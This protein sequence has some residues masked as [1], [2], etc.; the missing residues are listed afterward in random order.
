MRDDIVAVLFLLAGGVIG[1]VSGRFYLVYGGVALFLLYLFFWEL[2]RSK[3]SRAPK[4]K[5]N[6]IKKEETKEPAGSWTTGL[7]KNYR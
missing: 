6:P 4:Q 7:F 1:F 2:K 3:D 5:E